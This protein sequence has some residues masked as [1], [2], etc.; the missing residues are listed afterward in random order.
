MP[1]TDKEIHILLALTGSVAAIKAPLLV[2]L[3]K[4]IEIPEHAVKVEV[5]T[6]AH[7]KHFYSLSQ[8]VKGKRINISSIP[9]AASFESIL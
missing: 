9:G 7:A 1:Q 5:I 6:T 2:P 3:L 4:K 8:D